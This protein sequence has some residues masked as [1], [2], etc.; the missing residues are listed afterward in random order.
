MGCCCKFALGVSDGLWFVWIH[1]FHHFDICIISCFICNSW[2]S[3]VPD[4][5]HSVLN[6]VLIP[7]HD[8]TNSHVKLIHYRLKSEDVLWIKSLEKSLKEKKWRILRVV[9]F[10]LNASLLSAQIRKF[11]S[12]IEYSPS[13][14]RI[15]SH[16]ISLKTNLSRVLDTKSNRKSK[17][18][19]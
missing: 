1:Y 16:Q 7:T 4:D 13:P 8:M 14:P 11:F 5:V 3:V 6:A 18:Q 2:D 19:Q 15:F 12:E 10:K 9:T 17:T